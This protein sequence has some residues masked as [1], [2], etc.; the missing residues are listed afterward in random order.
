VLRATL[1]LRRLHSGQVG[2]SITW[3]VVGTAT[4]GGLLATLLR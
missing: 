3:L 2:D 4:L 1:A